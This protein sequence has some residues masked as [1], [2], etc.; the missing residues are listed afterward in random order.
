[1]ETAEL[2]NRVSEFRNC[3][4]H[5]GLKVTPQRI[6]VFKALLA[7]REHPS[8]DMVYKEVRRDYPNISLDT[9]NRTLGTISNIGQAFTVEGSG[10]ARRYDADLSDHQHFRCLRCKKI[11][12]F[13]HSDF[14][15]VM[16]PEELKNYDIVR[17]TVYF[18]GFCDDCKNSG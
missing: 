7:S 13:H 18:E 4:R 16:V 15:N 8:A 10:D 14:D 9:V 2:Q 6:A 5:A 3:C 1:M 12:D 17:K 11:I